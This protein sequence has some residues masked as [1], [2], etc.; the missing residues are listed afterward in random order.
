MGSNW[1]RIKQAVQAVLETTRPETEPRSWKWVEASVWTER[2]LAALENG[3]KGGKWY[4]LMDKVYALSTLTAA[5][6]QVKANKGTAGIDHISIACAEPV[7][8]N[9]LRHKQNGTYTNCIKPY[10]QERTSSLR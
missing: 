10:K 9:A 3:V 2:M 6:Q 8:V 4:S 1:K 5:W 7:K